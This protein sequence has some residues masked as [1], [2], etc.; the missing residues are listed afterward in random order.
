MDKDSYAR[1]GDYYKILDPICDCT[2]GI[3]PKGHI[4]PIEELVIQ[5]KVPTDKEIGDQNND[6]VIDES[7]LYIYNTNSHIGVEQVQ[8][9]ISIFDKFIS[10]LKSILGGLF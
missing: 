2:G 9:N 6:G 8:Q 7:D 1:L 5:G 4:C 10:W 3:A